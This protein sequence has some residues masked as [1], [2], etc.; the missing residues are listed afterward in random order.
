M[1][2]SM[3]AFRFKTMCLQNFGVVSRRRNDITR[4]EIELIV[5]GDSVEE[6]CQRSLGLGSARL[7]LSD[8]TRVEDNGHMLMWRIQDLE[9]AQRM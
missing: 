5:R 1:F 9:E 2:L 4:R 8:R 6:S 7:L 3:L